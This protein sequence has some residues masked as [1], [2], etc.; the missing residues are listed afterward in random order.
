MAERGLR[1][2]QAVIR[3]D[4]DE[5]DAQFQRRANGFIGIGL[6]DFGIDAAERRRAKGEGG[7]GRAICAE[8][9]VCIRVFTFSVPLLVALV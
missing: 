8:G 7:Y 3:G 1:L 4:I 6:R 9:V 2:C 5:I